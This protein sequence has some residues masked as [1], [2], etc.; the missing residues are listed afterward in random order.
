[1]T[2]E[3]WMMKVTWFFCSVW[4][5]VAEFCDLSVVNPVSVHPSLVS[6]VMLVHLSSELDSKDGAK[7]FSKQPNRIQRVARGSGVA[8]RDVQELLTQYTKFAQMVKKMGGIKGLFKG[9][10]GWLCVWGRGGQHCGDWAESHLCVSGGDMSKN[11]NPSQMAKLNQQMAK[12]MDPRV[13]H[14]MGESCSACLSHVH[15]RLSKPWRRSVN[16]ADGRLSDWQT[17]NALTWPSGRALPHGPCI[18]CCC[19]TIHAFN[20]KV[21]QEVTTGDRPQ[22]TGG[23]AGCQ[24]PSLNLLTVLLK[25]IYCINL[26]KS[27]VH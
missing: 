13:L 1:M 22:S 25:Y 16:M 26:C 20:L 12:M 21:Q 9:R 8:T 2:V 19:F 5:V 6:L 10:G 23:S 4:L 14:H 7:L 11:V 24:Q 17:V 27:T 18:S 3:L 15:S